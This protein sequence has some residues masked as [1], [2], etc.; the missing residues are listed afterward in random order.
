MSTT[1][2][3]TPTAPKFV[4]YTRVSTEEQ[5]RSGLGLEAQTEAIRQAVA[6]KGGTIARAFSEVGS[7]GDDHRPELLAALNLCKLTKA[8][9]IVAKL[10]RLSRD[11]ELIAGTMKR[12][13]LVVAECVGASPMELHLRASFAEEERNKIRVRT[14]EALARLKARG[15]K[16]GS[17]RPGHWKGREDRRQAGQRN[18]VKVAAA[19]RR[20]ESAKLY[21]DAA[22][23]AAKFKGASLR[24]LADELNAAGLTTPRGSVWTAAAVSRMLQ[25]TAG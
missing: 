4:S 18:A 19:K 22:R 13:P 2:T 3:T 7:G 14:R 17:A 1:R 11:V 16:L 23:I 24:G 25:A 10:D 15:V 12:T 8:T 20:A 5:G 21:A 6:A 9:L